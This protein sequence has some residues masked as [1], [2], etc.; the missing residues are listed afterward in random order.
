[1]NMYFTCIIYRRRKAKSRSVSEVDASDYGAPFVAKI[2]ICY[3]L[4]K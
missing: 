4:K 3:C 1:M 2:R